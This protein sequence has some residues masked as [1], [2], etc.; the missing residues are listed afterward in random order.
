MVQLACAVHIE[1][2]DL[3]SKNIPKESESHSTN[4]TFRRDHPTFPSRPKEQH[5]QRVEQKSI[6]HRVEDLIARGFG[7]CLGQIVLHLAEIDETVDHTSIE[8][9]H[10]WIAH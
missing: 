10:D 4:L 3:L 6:L 8:I 7:T 5:A 9:E 1:P 2:A